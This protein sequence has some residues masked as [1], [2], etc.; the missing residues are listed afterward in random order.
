MGPSTGQWKRSWRV[1]FSLV[2]C[3]GI[4]AVGDARGLQ[5]L[6]PILGGIAFVSLT[7]FTREAIVDA[8]RDGGA[9]A[10]LVGG[11]LLGAIVTLSFCFDFAAAQFGYHVREAVITHVAVFA[12]A[13]VTTLGY[14]LRAGR[15][16]DSTHAFSWFPITDSVGFPLAGLFVLWGLALAL[17]EARQIASP[18]WLAAKLAFFYGFV[19]AIAMFALPAQGLWMRADA[20]RRFSAFVLSNLWPVAVVVLGSVTLAAYVRRV[21]ATGWDAVQTLGFA[22]TLAAPAIAA[23]LPPW[24]LSRYEIRGGRRHSA[25]PLNMAAFRRHVTRTHLV[26]SLILRENAGVFFV[27]LPLSVAFSLSP[28]FQLPDKLPALAVASAWI[29]ATLAWTSVLMNRLYLIEDTF[30]RAYAA[31]LHRVVQ[32]Q[33][34]QMLVLGYGDI[35]RRFLYEQFHKETVPFATL[36]DHIDGSSD[37]VMPSGRIG[38]VFTRVLIVEGGDPRA[39]GAILSPDGLYLTTREVSNAIKDADN[40]DTGRRFVDYVVP[41]IVGDPSD[42][43]VLQGAGF[44]DASFVVCAVEEQDGSAASQAVLQRLKELT[45]R[46]RWIPAAM[47]VH[48]SML[49]PYITQRVLDHDLQLHYIFPEHLE[50]LNAANV[51]HAAVLKLLAVHPDRWPTVAICGHGKRA[52]YLVDSF[53]KNLSSSELDSLIG[54]QHGDPR[55]V[56]IGKGADGEGAGTELSALSGNGTVGNL[57]SAGL[58]VGELA[59]I[60]LVGRAT[61]GEKDGKPWN[62][63]SGGPL[64]VPVIRQEPHDLAVWH[65]LLANWWPDIVVFADPNAEGELR[66][67]HAVV[68]SLVRAEAG[69]PLPLLVLSGETGRRYEMREFESALVY[70]SSLHTTKPGDAGADRYYLYPSPGLK[71]TRQSGLFRG[72]CLVDVL[73]DP[74]Q[75]LGAMVKAYCPRGPGP[76]NDARRIPLELNFCIADQTSVMATTLA[77]MSG[78]RPVAPPNG[79]GDF[80]S[81]SNAKVIPLPGDEFVVRS[82]AYMSSSPAG[83]EPSFERLTVS[84]ATCTKLADP[85]RVLELLLRPSAPGSVSMRQRLAAVTDPAAFT[86]DFEPYAKQAVTHIQRCCGM[87]NCPIEATHKVAGSSAQTIASRTIRPAD[88]RAGHGKALLK[89]FTFDDSGKEPPPVQTTDKGFASIRLTCRNGKKAGTLAQALNALLFRS[90]VPSEDAPAW[91]FNS[92]Y[93][94][95]YECHDERYAVFT[96]YGALE[97]PLSNRAV[98]AIDDVLEQIEIKPVRDADAWA[99]Y[100][101]RLCSHLGTGYAIRDESVDLVGRRFLIKRARPARYQ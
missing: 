7:L 72:D 52:F 86:H 29:A 20:R 15:R 101:A 94:S 67:M 63:V 65:K 38:K 74:V 27:N 56:L 4:T 78:L 71:R 31:D 51:L 9:P 44:D 75:R 14:C 10:P 17:F 91:V 99:D 87:L 2:L 96:C 18:F 24:A 58:S 53:L 82:F 92:T 12:C 22:W 93:V 70:Y 61:T 26:S 57:T 98:P 35:G 49:A 21:G 90:L 97:P 11:A 83:L 89:H 6:Y 33:R 30:A 45:A 34:H 62:P 1:G 39:K 28:L 60:R 85:L 13:G 81:L 16:L 64:A 73:D 40:V 42:P 95:A 80:P 5:V 77:W 88:L 55:V 48:T 8:V 25:K 3:A 84:G 41:S 100:A 69:K 50:G 36:A 37:I 23:A 43:R 79:H 32:A 46:E 54:A 68:N 76:Q 66:A 59:F 19:L 47:T